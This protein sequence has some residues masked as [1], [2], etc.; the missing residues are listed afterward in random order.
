MEDME[1]FRIAFYDKV[2]KRSKQKIHRRE[3]KEIVKFLAY[4]INLN[5]NLFISFSIG[6]NDFT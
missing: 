3:E 1:S 2:E 4:S 6:L 5:D